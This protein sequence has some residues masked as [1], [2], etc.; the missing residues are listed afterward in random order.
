MRRPIVRAQGSAYPDQPAPIEHDDLVVL[1]SSDEPLRTGQVH[2]TLGRSAHAQ[3]AGPGLA[4]LPLFGLIESDFQK[5]KRADRLG[6]MGTACPGQWAR[7]WE[8]EVGLYQRSARTDANLAHRH[9]CC[10]YRHNV[11]S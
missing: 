4:H 7:I 11:L 9:M 2:C 6:P 5:P 10:A 8:L 3:W 1:L